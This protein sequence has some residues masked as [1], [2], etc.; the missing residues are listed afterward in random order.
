MKLDLTNPIFH[1]EDAA[2]AHLEALRWPHGPVCPRCGSLH[3]TRL[4]GKS[5]RKGLIHCNDCKKPFTVT[6]DS[7]MERS[8]IPLAKWVLGFH[9]MAASKKGVSSHQLHRMLGITYKSAWFLSMRIREAMGLAPEADSEP[10]G[11]AGKAVETDE[12]NVGG[13]AKNVHKG[14]PI[15]PKR[16]VVA[17]VERG[18]KLKAKQVTNVDAK[19]IRK[20][21]NNVDRKSHLLTDDSLIYYHLGPT[22]AKHGAVNHSADEYVRGDAPLNTVESFFALPKRGVYGNFHAVS[23]QHLQRYVNEATF[24]WNNRIKLGIHDA[25][26]A[27]NAI[28]GARGK[29]LMYR[30]PRGP[31]RAG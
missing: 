24:K 22:F 21:L 15:P 10:L 4:A 11:G 1:N 30:Q 14:K 2:R 19:N 18:G 23:E 28:K 9:L 13:K 8:K 20:V 6:V 26:R 29:R 27:N 17:L 25:E 7:V 31:V 3:V 16:P 5:H 12:T